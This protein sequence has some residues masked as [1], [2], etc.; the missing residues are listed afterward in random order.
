MTSIKTKGSSKGF[1]LMEVMIVVAIV[2][3]LAAIAIPSY[4][5][6]VIRSKRGDAMGALLSAAQAVERYKA[7]NNFSYNGAS[8]PFTQVPADGGTAYYT[9]AIVTPTAR[10][11]TI[12]ATPVAGSSQDGDGALTINE[13]GAKTWNGNGCWPESGNSC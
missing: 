12:T 11:Y 9:L 4:Q 13:S 10:T 6:Y 2:G 7:A 3:I 5:S 1:T 8:L